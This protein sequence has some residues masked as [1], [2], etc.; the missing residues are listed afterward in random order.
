[1]PRLVRRRPF[2]E[3]VKAFLNPLDFLLWLSEELETRDW[4]QLEKEWALPVGV[5]L[6]VVMLIVRA[7][8]ASGSRV[9]SDIFGDEGPSWLSRFVRASRVCPQASNVC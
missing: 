9:D 4:D 6:N 5:G 8:S 1:M 3:R 2:T 7:N